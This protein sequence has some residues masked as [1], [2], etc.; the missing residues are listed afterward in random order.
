[1]TLALTPAA[2]STD[3][4]LFDIVTA[5]AAV[6]APDEEIAIALDPA[7]A[8]AVIAL[9]ARAG[10]EP[11]AIW[12][13]GWALLL[14]RL[15]GTLRARLAKRG[16]AGWTALAIDVP[17][18]GELAPW[19][20][21]IAAPAAHG[22][23]GASNGVHAAVSDAMPQSAWADA[24]TA[25]GDGAPALI[26]HLRTAGE[27]VARFSGARI[28]RATAERLG[29][30]VR[31]VVAAI[32]APGARLETISPL[33]AAE[34]AR[35]VDEW[36]RTDAGYRSEA[37]VHGLFRERAAA[38]PERAAI[39]ADGLTLS[40]GELDRWSDAL[41]ERLIAAG[42][43]TDQPVALCLERSVEA[44]VA[45]LAILK[46]G[47]AYLPLDPDYPAERLAFAVGDAG[48]RVLVT[49][50]RAPASPTA[51]ASRSAG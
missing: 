26:W 11:V 32:A 1:M 22:A 49:S 38:H 14:A 15:A 48:A 33:S 29:E 25:S 37:T 2:D 44:V 27:A 30:L 28:D 12:R 7:G 35:V 3:A 46:A 42:V 8:A 18:A 21:A 4:D 23:N 41:A 19:L 16:G 34:R 40:Y 13:A 9:A 5:P 36:N 10:I 24:A 17:A 47:G 50:T 20:A 45:A 43:A 51:N 31:G 39:V 6:G